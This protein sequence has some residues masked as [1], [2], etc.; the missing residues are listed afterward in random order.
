MSADATSPRAGRFRPA[1]ACA[2]QLSLLHVFPSF[3]IGGVP[4]RM[5][6]I[7]NHFGKQFR[8]TI[9]ALDGNL[10]A[11]G[12]LSSGAEISLITPTAR[13]SGTV[14][15]T[16]SAGL[17]LR[18]VGPDLLITYNWGSIEWAIANRVLPRA[19]H[20]HFE[21]GFGKEEAD[22]Q[23]RRRV[24]CRRWALARCT[25]VVVPSHRLEK[26]ARHSWRLPADLVCYLPNGVDV[27]RFSAPARDAIPGFTRRPGELIVG[28]VAPLRPEK[29]IGRLLRVFA[30]LDKTLPVRLVVAGDGTERGA[31]ARLAQELGISDRVMFTGQVLPESVLG[32]FD[33]FALSS[34]TEQMPNA[35]LEAMA[36]GLPVASVDVGD[37]KAMVSRD[38]QNFIVARDDAAAFAAA[39]GR[40]LHEPATRERLGCQN[41]E[42]VIADFSLQ[43]MFDRYSEL[44]L[45]HLARGQHD[46]GNGTLHSAA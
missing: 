43:R 5:C 21:A 2:T 10:D 35:I 41:R 26:I 11:A 6:R 1:L 4:L 12:Q 3:G 20:I 38:N 42:R 27:E 22:T 45:G 14:Y 7:I 25:R 19:P 8:H 9:V 18:R 39:V 29:N 31:L 37:V 15:G 28:T 44:F 13:K 17:T 32:S 34:D 36:A 24:L 30:M 23:L 40:L 16:V 33:I 46:S